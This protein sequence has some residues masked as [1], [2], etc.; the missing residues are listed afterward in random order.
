[1]NRDQMTVVVV[2]HVIGTGNDTVTCQD[3][4]DYLDGTE[5]TGETE[6]YLNMS[7]SDVTEDF[8]LYM[9]NKD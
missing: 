4:R 7:P 2:E 8:D 5:D 1:M 9:A 3:V 6:L